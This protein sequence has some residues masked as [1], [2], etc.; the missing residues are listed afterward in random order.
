MTLAEDICPV[1]TIARP[2]MD[3]AIEAATPDQPYL[4]PAGHH[5]VAGH[6]VLRVEA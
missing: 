1:P 3:A 6:Y 2:D 4:V 5:I